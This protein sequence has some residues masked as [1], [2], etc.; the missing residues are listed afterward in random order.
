VFS[1]PADL[2]HPD[3]KPRARGRVRDS[4]RAERKM[5]GGDFSAKGRNKRMADKCRLARNLFE[6]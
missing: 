6:R 4:D 5:R 1:H 2:L 3:A